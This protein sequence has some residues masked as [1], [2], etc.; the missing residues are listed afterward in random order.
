MGELELAVAG[1]ATTNRWPYDLAVESIVF[2]GTYSDGTTATI[3]PI[4]WRI[5]QSTRSRPPTWGPGYEI[6]TVVRGVGLSGCDFDGLDPESE[7][8]ARKAGLI[9]GPTGLT[10][11]ILSGRLPCVVD[12]GGVEVETSVDFQLDLRN[13]TRSDRAAPTNLRLSL[14]G[15]ITGVE[16]VDDWFEDGM[17]R[18]EAAL[19]A[20][21][22]LRCCVTCL[23]S[24]YSPAGHGLMGMFC[25][26]GAKEQYLAVKS[27]ADYWGVPVTEEVVET[28]LC[29]DYVRRVAGTGYRG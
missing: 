2:D 22:R 27:K 24:D 11:C 14:S 23:Y 21:F 7:D 25:H 4:V 18:L 29:E 20:D 8:G 17:I 9:V 5:A 28:Y 10:D 26:R 6:H 1:C 15:D 19:P 12:S 3:E 13:E 16:I